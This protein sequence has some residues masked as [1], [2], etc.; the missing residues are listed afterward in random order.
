MHAGVEVVVLRTPRSPRRAWCC[1]TRS[2]PTSAT[3]PRRPGEAERGRARRRARG[4]RQPRPCASSRCSAV[5]ERA[6]PAALRRWSATPSARVADRSPL[7]RDAEPARSRGPRRRHRRAPPAARRP[8]PMIGPQVAAARDARPV[9]HRRPRRAHPH[10]PARHRVHRGRRLRA[11]R[12]RLLRPWPPAHPGAQS[13]G[14]DAQRCW[15]LRRALR[16]R[17]ESR[18]SRSSR[19][20]W[21][22]AWRRRARHRGGPRWSLLAASVIA[23]VLV[24]AV[25]RLLHR[26]AAGAR[27][28]RAE[29]RL[30]RPDATRSPAP[31][32]R[33]LPRSPSPPGG[34]SPQVVVRDRDGHVLWAGQLGRARRQQVVGLGPFDVTATDGSAVK[35]SRPRASP[36]ATV[37]ADGRGRQQARSG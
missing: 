25:A 33:T 28:P 4:R 20:S 35:V 19:P 31:R 29:H 32:P 18:P 12:R 11:V 1:R 21:P 37:G 17:A 6:R 7:Q 9:E 16:R 5:R 2:A 36:A 22:P 3:S 15:T 8:T 14:V 13:F 24:W 26:A 23:L 30:R 27:Q 34:A 10:P